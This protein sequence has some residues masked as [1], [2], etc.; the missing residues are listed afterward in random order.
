[1]SFGLAEGPLLPLPLRPHLS[2]PLRLPPRLLALVFGEEALREPLVAVFLLAAPLG[3][4]R[5]FSLCSLVLQLKL[6]AEALGVGLEAI[7][8]RACDGFVPLDSVAEATS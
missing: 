7:I 5:P 2:F 3:L 8:L 4:G 1:L 6:T